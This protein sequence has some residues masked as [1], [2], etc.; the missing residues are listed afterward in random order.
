MAKR[1]QEYDYADAE[2]NKQHYGSE[3]APELVF[4]S[5]KNQKIAIFL[6]EED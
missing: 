1:F 4:R 6:G 5:I 2:L 3:E